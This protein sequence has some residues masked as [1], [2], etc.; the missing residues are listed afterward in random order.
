MLH[1][2]LFSIFS[3]NLIRSSQ[4][5]TIIAQTWDFQQN[6]GQR[7]PPAKHNNIFA[8]KT[9]SSTT[10]PPWLITTPSFKS[11]S[12]STI[13]PFTLFHARAPLI[14][15]QEATSNLTFIKP[16]HTHLSL[17]LISCLWFILIK[18][19]SRY[20]IMVKKN[21]EV[22]Y[23][24]IGRSWRWPRGGLGGILGGVETGYRMV[25]TPQSRDIADVIRIHQVID[26]T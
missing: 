4:Q 1:A 11:W 10:S 25:W 7:L 26:V 14:S 24:V 3:I 15:Y 23:L 13:E 22:L 20:D 6:L 16:Y 17:Q 2:I 18:G 19:W 5:F 12:C 8:L 21:I 9:L